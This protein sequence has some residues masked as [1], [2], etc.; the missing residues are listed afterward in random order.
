M[1][2][3]PRW[4]S[5]INNISDDRK[6]TQI[7]PPWGNPYKILYSLAESAHHRKENIVIILYLCPC[8]LFLL[9]FDVVILHEGVK[10]IKY[11]AQ[12]CTLRHHWRNYDG[13]H[14]I[15]IDDLCN[16]YN[17]Q[18]KRYPTLFLAS[19]LYTVPHG[20]EKTRRRATEFAW[21][22]SVGYLQDG[23]PTRPVPSAL[24]NEV[25]SRRNRY[26]YVS[27]CHVM[28]STPR[29]PSRPVS[30][31]SKM[32]HLV[33]F[34]C[35]VIFSDQRRKQEEKEKEKKRWRLQRL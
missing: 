21:D 1:D 28:I 10:T 17:K 24:E 7:V 19:R 29:V 22:C 13:W 3:L 15:Q 30:L 33:S 32:S 6:N 11:N 2:N 9:T 27:S 14:K 5:V 12:A 16:R 18:G 31:L 25:P 26:P 20:S 4:R 23:V 35:C 34:R 8:I